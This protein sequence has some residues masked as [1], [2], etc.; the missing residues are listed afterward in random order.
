MD[1]RIINRSPWEIGRA[2]WNQRDLYTRNTSIDDEGYGRGP[3]VHPELGSYAYVRDEPPPSG[4]PSVAEHGPP[5]RVFEDYYEGEAWPWRIYHEPEEKEGTPRRERSDY[6]IEEDVRSAL[7]WH[8]DLDASDIDVT[9][10]GGEVTLRGTV[11]D[12]RSKRVAG[13]VAAACDGVVGVHNRLRIVR[14]DGAD[15]DPLIVPLEPV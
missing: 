15:I 2:H 5:V 11:H 10:S 1:P 6:E 4:E 13:E 3:S 9:V 7:T 8:R 14:G 12:R